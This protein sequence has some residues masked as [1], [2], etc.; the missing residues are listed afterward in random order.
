MNAEPDLR[1]WISQAVA[2]LGPAQAEL[3]GRLTSEPRMKRVWREFGRRRR[4][5]G[6]PL[7]PVE[8]P[9]LLLM[10]VLKLTKERAY[11]IPRRDATMARD[12]YLAVAEVLKRDAQRF[13]DFPQ[14]HS[15]SEAEQIAWSAKVNCLA[16][17]A[18]FYDDLA[19]S[20][21]EDSPVVVARDTGDA[22][23][24]FFALALSTFCREQLGTPLHAQVATIATVVFGRE[25]TRDAVREWAGD[26]KPKKLPL[27]PGS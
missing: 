13:T 12:H 6:A 24:R 1:S 11:V 21:A 20:C 22:E 4:S 14:T 10:E 17:A 25:I 2:A 18:R 15:R 27:S 9:K 8:A 23:A 3:L 7:Y 26:K 16:E 5:D 19:A